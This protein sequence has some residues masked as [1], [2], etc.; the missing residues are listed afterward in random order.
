[1]KL[2]N[3][4]CSLEHAKKLKELGV[5]QENIWWWVETKDNSYKSFVM[6]EGNLFSYEKELH[7]FYSAFTV[8]ELGE[9]LPPYITDNGDFPS[10]DILR[11][12]DSWIFNYRVGCAKARIRIEDESLSD[13]MAKMLIWL[14]ENKKVEV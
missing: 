14:I 8:A 7:N 4:V 6:N 9:M 3:Q 10:L 2:E 11:T 1:M 12:K 13:A 5:K